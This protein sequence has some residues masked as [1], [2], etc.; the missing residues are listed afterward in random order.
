MLKNYQKASKLLLF[1]NF[2]LLFPLTPTT[3]MIREE[4]DLEV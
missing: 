2:I 3:E 4:H 1:F